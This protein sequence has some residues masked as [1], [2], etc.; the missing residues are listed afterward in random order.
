MDLRRMTNSG[1]SVVEHL[2]RH[3]MVKGSSPSTIIAKMFED[4]NP[5][6][7]QDNDTQHNDIQHNDIQHY[8]TQ[9]NYTQHNDTQQ[10]DSQ[11]N[12]KKT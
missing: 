5:N 1:S 4:S 8:E 10:D 7:T 11:Y 12:N 2:P 6:L 9:H 3:L